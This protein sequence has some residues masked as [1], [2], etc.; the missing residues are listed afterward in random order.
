MSESNTTD[1][2]QTIL[3]AL[4]AIAVLVVLSSIFVGPVSI[5]FREALAALTNQGDPTHQIILIEIRLA[6]SLVAFTAGAALGVAGAALQGLLRNPLADPGVLGVSACAALSS[7]GAIYFGLAGHLAVATPVFAI[8]GALAATVALLALGAGRVSTTRLILIGVGLSSFAGALISLL[9]NLAPNPFVLSDLVNWLFGTV[10]NRGFYDLSLALP[11]IGVGLA[12]LL[13]KARDLAALSLGEETATTLGVSLRILTTVVIA[14]S[15]LLVGA[16][17]ALAG[18]IGFV[19]IVAPHVA[20]PL[21][22]H[23]PD[24]LLVPSG[25]IAGTML[26]AADLI[27]RVL[28][29]PQELKLG[30]VAALIGAPGF[31]WIAA[32]TRRLA[33]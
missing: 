16:S 12:L 17:V 28:P 4:A 15:S 25:L 18:S 32:T 27:I 26:C 21:V 31:I 10:A 8:F 9:M 14:G 3:P 19:G 11:F 30:V 20:R 29:F 33:R 24:R 5:G 22:H 2:S 1:V 7:V 13:W 23:N 6:R